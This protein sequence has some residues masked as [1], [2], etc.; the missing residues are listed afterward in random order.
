MLFLGEFLFFNF[1][2]IYMVFI[3]ELHLF[4]LL[5]RRQFN[6]FVYEY[7]LPAIY[8]QNTSQ[9]VRAPTTKMVCFC[10]YD[11]LYHFTFLVRVHIHVSVGVA[12]PLMT[13]EDIL[14]SSIVQVSLQQST[15]ELELFLGSSV[16]TM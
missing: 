6:Y 12:F 5:D 14:V 15:M 1:S 16:K 11:C 7:R 9:A 10:L 4:M 13:R 8:T 2:I 3:I